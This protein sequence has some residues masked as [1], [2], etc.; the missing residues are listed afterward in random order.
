MEKEIC[1]CGHKKSEH[2]HWQRSGKITKCLY[3]YLNCNDGVK[4]TCRC[5]KF[6]LK[7]L[8]ED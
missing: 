6:E 1:E 3:D 5:K 7:K 8:E 2:Q 4:R